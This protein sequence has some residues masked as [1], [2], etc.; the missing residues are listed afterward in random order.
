MQINSVGVSSSFFYV[1]I[2]SEDVN[3]PVGGSYENLTS[4]PI[5]CLVNLLM[6]TDAITLSVYRESCSFILALIPRNN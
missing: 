2:A 1:A 4:A 3:A 5:W 6:Y